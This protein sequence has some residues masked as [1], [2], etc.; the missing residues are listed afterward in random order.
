MKGDTKARN[1]SYQISLGG[2][3]QPGWMT[4]N[5]V[6]KLENLPPVEGGNKLYKPLT[7]EVEENEEVAEPDQE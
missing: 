3:Q 4:I 2:N 1:E 6:R 7:G 5:E